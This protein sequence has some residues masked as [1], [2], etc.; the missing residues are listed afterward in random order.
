[1]RASDSSRT[2]E[3]AST[4][5]GSRDAREPRIGVVVIGRNEGERLERS[6]RSVGTDS[7]RLPLRGL[8]LH[9][10]QPRAGPAAGLR[11]RR[12]RRLDALHSRTR[13][14][15]RA[16]AAPGDRRLA[17]DGSV[18]GRRLRTGDGLAQPGAGGTRPG[19]EPRRRL[20]ALARALPRCVALRDAQSDGVEQAGGRDARLRRHRNVQS[21]CPERCRRLQL[22]DDR[23]RGA[24][25]LLP[26][27]SGGVEDRAPGRGDGGARWRH[28]RRFGSGGVAPYG[29]ATRMQRMR[30]F[31]PGRN[32]GTRPDRWRACCYGVSS[33]QSGRW[34]APRWRSRALGP[35]SFP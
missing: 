4:P 5:G 26:A 9:G 27:A 29:T 14:K 3:A 22:L 8:G 17:G 11:G 10:R 30:L 25:A 23:R 28:D 24:R 1:M 18:R 31:R 16:E 21:R 15:R 32:D 20:R 7:C 13:A 34:P 35:P 6:L 19:P 12:A 33:P 2:N